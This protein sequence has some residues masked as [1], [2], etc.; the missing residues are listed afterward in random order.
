MVE[1]FAPINRT[2]SFILGDRGEF[3]RR[4]APE[5]GKVFFSVYLSSSLV[6]RF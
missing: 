2:F 4:F 3:R 1:T 5:K 6:A